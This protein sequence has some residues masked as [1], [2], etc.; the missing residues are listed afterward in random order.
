MPIEVRVPPH[1]QHLPLDFA[2]PHARV[3]TAEEPPAG[4][5]REERKETEGAFVLYAA[6]SGDLR[7]RRKGRRRG[8]GDGV[9]G[10]E[11]LAGEG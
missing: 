6:A 3:P 2:R 10:E 1:I 9:V 11:G 4:S 8:E 7:R 5:R